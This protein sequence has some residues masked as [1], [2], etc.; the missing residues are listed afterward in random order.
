MSVIANNIFI[1]G[2]SQVCPVAQNVN[3]IHRPN[4]TLC[5][6]PSPHCIIQGEFIF[7]DVCVLNTV[8]LTWS[9]PQLA[10]SIDSYPFGR[11]GHAACVMGDKIFIY[12]GIVSAK[13][14]GYFRFKVVVR[15]Q[16]Q[17]H[18]WSLG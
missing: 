3:A 16:P 9:E 2:G 13:E 18:N 1:Y 5:F 6:S 7:S 4:A 14:V 8:T 10:G 12:G 15:K 11:Y 17:L